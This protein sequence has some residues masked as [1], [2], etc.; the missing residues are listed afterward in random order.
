MFHCPA[1]LPGEF[2]GR[3]QLSPRNPLADLN[4]VV[5]LTCATLPY[6]PFTDVAIPGTLSMLRTQ[7]YK[8][9]PSPG[10]LS[11]GRSFGLDFIKQLPAIVD[12]APHFDENHRSIIMFT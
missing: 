3:T 4:P 8:R 11:G 1:E 5:W 6:L 7:V 9:V 12:L 10:L 2:H